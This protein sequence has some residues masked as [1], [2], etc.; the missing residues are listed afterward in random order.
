MALVIGAACSSSA[1]YTAES[2]VINSALGLGA[3]VQQRS[4][5]GCFAECV[6]GTFCNP[7]TGLCERS[8]C[9]TC[10]PGEVC[11]AA[12]DGWRCATSEEAGKVTN[13]VRAQLPPAG[14]V[15][16]GLGI[17]PQTGSG[18]PQPLHPGPDQP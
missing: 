18:P 10:P 11:V 14:R 12:D 4:A 2:A 9:G 17:S 7:R 3:A 16:P 5:G 15:V 6:H 13:G 1:P 8:P